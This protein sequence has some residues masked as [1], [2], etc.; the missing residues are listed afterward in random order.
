MPLRAIG[1]ALLAVGAILLVFG[2]NSSDSLGSQIS[3]FFSGSPTD[4]TIWLLIGGV[5]ALVVGLFMS[6]V[7]SRKTN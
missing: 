2:I 5:A 4:K 3:E 6:F 1:L 7:P